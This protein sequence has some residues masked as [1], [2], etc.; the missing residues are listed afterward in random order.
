MLA[1]MET[2][3]LHVIEA[4]SFRLDAADMLAALQMD[5]S[6]PF[7]DDVA[8][9]VQQACA[10]ARPRGLYRLSTVVHED[11]RTVRIDGVIFTSRVLR[12][13]VDKLHR[14]FPFV[15]TCGAELAAWAAALEDPLQRFWA[16]GI[17]EKALRAAIEALARHLNA[18]YQPGRRAI[19]NPGSLEDWPLEQQTHLFGLLGNP[20]EAIGV[21]LS[22]S[23]L[24]WPIKSVSGIWFETEKRYENCQLCPREL[25]PNRRA[26]YKPGLLA[27]D[28]ELHT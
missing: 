11:D 15:A 19:M 16:D 17:M 14:V 2:E 24:M 3:T 28:Y 18:T 10:I 7:A 21:S 1:V 8:R 26:P 5:A 9:L 22:E 25:C 12:V 20:K 4:D 6:A 23:F 27:E 13:N